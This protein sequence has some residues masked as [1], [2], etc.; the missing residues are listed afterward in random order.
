[1]KFIVG[2]KLKMGQIWKE[3]KVIPVTIIEAGPCWVTQIMDKEKNGYQSVQVGFEKISKEKKITKTNKTKPF[4][5]LKEFRG[6]A[7][8]M[9][10][11]DMID[12]ASFQ[13]G[14]VVKISGTTKGK[15][16]QG[17]T[18]RYGFRGAATASHGNKHNHRTRGSV[19]CRWP[20]RVIKGMR[21]PGHMGFARKSIRN[22]EIVKID[23]ENNLIAIRGCVPGAAGTILEIS[24]Q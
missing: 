24:G 7:G 3:D 20:Q 4:E 14:D 16:Y 13:E 2:K 12:A 15:G 19:G 11:G 23:K 18:K 6:E 17:G 21:M 1:M 9:K 22:A 8:E 10:A 5:I